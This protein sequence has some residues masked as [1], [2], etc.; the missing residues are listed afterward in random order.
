MKVVKTVAFTDGLTCERCLNPIE[1]HDF[2]AM[3][4][5]SLSEC[6]DTIIWCIHCADEVAIGSADMDWVD[7]KHYGCMQCG[8]VIETSKAEDMGWVVD[9]A[10][11][12]VYCFFCAYESATGSQVSLPLSSSTIPQERGT[13]KRG[14]LKTVL[15]I[16]SGLQ[17]VLIWDIGLDWLVL[18]PSL[19]L[20]F[21]AVRLRKLYA[22]EVEFLPS[23]ESEQVT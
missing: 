8:F 7:G 1:E 18:I 17:M 19:A 11:I 22:R 14:G 10:G 6:G 21:L 2:I 9:P 16:A 20:G 23:A 12:G 4:M 3:L 5:E 15:W 13:L